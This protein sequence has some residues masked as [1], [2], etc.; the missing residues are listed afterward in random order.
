[1]LINEYVDKNADGGGGN[2]QFFEC[3]LTYVFFK[4]YIFLTRGGCKKP[5]KD[6][7]EQKHTFKFKTHKAVTNKTEKL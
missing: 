3:A 4:I 2:K 6:A 7:V 5:E 1:M